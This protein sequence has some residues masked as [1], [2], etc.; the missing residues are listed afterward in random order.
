MGLRVVGCG[1]VG[2]CEGVTVGFDDG[3][4][5][6]GTVGDPVSICR[7]LGSNGIENVVFSWASNS[8]PSAMTL[9]S[10]VVTV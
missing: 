10:A 5:V 2:I 3:G 4:L 7:L 6:C 9:P 1:V 8:P